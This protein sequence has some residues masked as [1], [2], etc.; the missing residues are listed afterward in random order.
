MGDT[1]EEICDLQDL[2]TRFQAQERVFAMSFTTMIILAASV[3]VDVLLLSVALGMKKTRE[4][5]FS[6]CPVCLSVWTVTATAMLLIGWFM[7]DL[8]MTQWLAQNSWL[9]GAG[10][11]WIGITMVFS[12]ASSSVA[13]TTG[14]AS[15]SEL[16]ANSMMVSVDVCV[17]GAAFALKQYSILPMAF[18][19][20]VVTV[21]MATLGVVLAG[22]F[23]QTIGRLAE[24]AGGAFLLA[25]SGFAMCR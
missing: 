13:P 11:G 18:I 5:S 23:R 4:N 24:V 25:A 8:F 21:L 20:A 6:H 3:S 12:G 19:V 10:L 22:Q 16:I 15:I 7:S 2:M 17:L 9:A 14:L 1:A